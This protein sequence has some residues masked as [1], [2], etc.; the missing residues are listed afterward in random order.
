MLIVQDVRR[1]VEREREIGEAQERF[2]RAF[3]DAPIGMAVAALDGRFLEV[4]QALCAITGYTS[5]QLTGTTFSM[6]THP[7]DVPRICR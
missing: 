7:E 2:R 4:N 1:R 5:E 6:I 3:E